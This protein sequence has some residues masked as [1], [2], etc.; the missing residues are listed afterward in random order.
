LP[1]TVSD[2]MSQDEASHGAPTGARTSSAS[3]ATSS[4]EVIRRGGMGSM[5]L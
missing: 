5:V 2:A 4:A 3:I 1:T